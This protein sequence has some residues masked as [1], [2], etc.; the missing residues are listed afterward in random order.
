MDTI[1]CSPKKAMKIDDVL[2]KKFWEEY[3][4]NRVEITDVAENASLFY[5]LWRC[6]VKN[7]CFALSGSFLSFDIKIG[8][9]RQ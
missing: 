4:K 7:I 5:S 3:K 9:F 1:I 6:L 8:K 2:R